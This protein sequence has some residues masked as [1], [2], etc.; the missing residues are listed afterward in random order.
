MERP[1]SSRPDPRIQS[2]REPPPPSAAVPSARATAFSPST[3]VISSL[4]PGGAH[5][6]LLSGRFECRCG[7]PPNLSRGLRGNSSLHALG[8]RTTR[9][10]A[11]RPRAII[12][13]G[14]KNSRWLFS[15]PWAELS[16]AYG[17]ADSGARSDR[18]QARAIPASRRRSHSATTHQDRLQGAGTG[19]SAEGTPPADRRRC[20]PPPDSA[21]ALRS[22]RRRRFSGREALSRLRPQPVQERPRFGLLA[23]SRVGYG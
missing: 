7:T 4:Q 23:R 1:V 16:W 3:R 10:P 9:E 14:V 22:G 17:A 18:F 15:R 21:F 19:Q 5:L 2:A 11:E 13:V 12:P 20:P 8:G 6:L